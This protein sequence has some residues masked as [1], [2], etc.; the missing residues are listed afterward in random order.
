MDVGSAPDPSQRVVVHLI[1]DST[2]SVRPAH[3]TPPSV[4]WGQ[5]LDQHFTADVVV[6]NHARSGRSAK[7]FVDEGLWDLACD[8]LE[9]DDYLIIHF[10]RNDQ[11]H[12]RPDLYAE[13]HGAYKEYL[14]RFVREAR[15]MGAAP[16][17]STPLARA[18]FD[19]HGRF[20][21]NMGEY[22]VA[23]R[24]LAAEEEAPLLD[25]HRES[26]AL[27]AS[28]GPEASKALVWWVEPG[29]DPSQPEGRRDIS[30]LSEAGAHAVCRMVAAELRATGHPLADYLAEAVRTK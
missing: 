12:D 22:P 8:Q 26:S 7:S 21:D 27:L 3:P 23:M 1:G 6:R 18:R 28:L 5:V 20:R 29:V 16:I 13:P 10:G 30:H 14:R 11:K 9:V 15:D 2:V 17:L 19:R 4:G 25:L 24:D